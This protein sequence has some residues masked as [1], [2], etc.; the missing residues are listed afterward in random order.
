MYFILVS[1]DLKQKKLYEKAIIKYDKDASIIYKNKYDDIIYELDTRDIKACIINLETKALDG[2]KLAR[3]IFEDYPKT[4]AILASIKDNALNSFRSHPFTFLVNPSEKDIINEL[5]DLK[6]TKGDLK[7]VAK[8]FGNFDLFV[9]DEA[10]KFKR[11][12]SK[13]L[14]AYLIYRRGTSTSASE[15]I[16]NLWEDKDVDRTTRSMIHNLISDIKQ[17]LADYNIEYIFSYE[18]NSY[19][20]N[21]N[22][23]ECD[24]YDFLDNPKLKNY[25]GDFLSNYEWA[26]Y[27][28]SNLE[29]IQN[30]RLDK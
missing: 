16:V 6:V 21:P 25:M 26:F 12:K 11:S 9:N 22:L 8:T 13:E 18:R 7:I 4:K 14:L 3:N 24:Y 20:I 5:N 19:R 30:E 10:I 15:L 1:E 17:T 28:S 29:A 2:L 23:I 27:V